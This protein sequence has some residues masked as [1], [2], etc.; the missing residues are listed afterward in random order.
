MRLLPLLRNADHISFKAMAALTWS[1]C[2][3]S[4]CLCP[5]Q[6]TQPW[7]GFIQGDSLSRS[8]LCEGRKGKAS[9]CGR[10]E[11]TCLSRAFRPTHRPGSACPLSFPGRTP[12]TPFPLPRSWTVPFIHPVLSHQNPMAQPQ[13]QKWC[14]GKPG[15][16]GR[17]AAGVWA[18]HENTAHGFAVLWRAPGQPRRSIWVCHI[19][20]AI[21]T[22]AQV[23]NEPCRWA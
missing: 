10:G 4:S 21:S 11:Q 19:P 20:R 17:G 7:Q 5:E 18:G 6:M 16:G 23:H 8:A 14:G 13:Q 12:R 1:Y 9:C 15:S 3:L 22:P 2:L